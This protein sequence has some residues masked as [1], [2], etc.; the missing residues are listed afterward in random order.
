MVT[1]SIEKERM[2]IA[3]KENQVVG[4]KEIFL[5]TEKEKLKNALDELGFLDN[6]ER[7]NSKLL[8]QEDQYKEPLA[9]S[10]TYIPD[11]NN[12]TINLNLDYTHP[13]HRQKKINTLLAVCSFQHIQEQVKEYVQQHNSNEITLVYGLALLNDNWTTYSRTPSIA[14]SFAQFIAD[15]NL[16]PDKPNLKLERVKTIMPLFDEQAATLK[17]APQD[18]WPASSGN[19]LTYL[20]AKK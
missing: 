10:Y 15:I 6:K 14:K 7:I 3:I 16:S 5:I 18:Q 9:T 1:K 20:I 17:F 13:D 19:A 8:K 4:L 12:A 11:I 2:F